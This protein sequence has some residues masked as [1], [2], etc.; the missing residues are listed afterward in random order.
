MPWG[1]K[2][3]GG[4]LGPDEEAW[5]EYDACALIEDG[6]RLPDLLVDQ[7]RGDDFLEGQLKTWLLEQAVRDAGMN[8]S[9]RMHDGYD[10]SYY[11]ISSFMADHIGWHAQ[12]LLA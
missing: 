1:E 12:K 5:R 9:I 4:Y 6:A 7:G 2:A 3:L 8:A 10:H 11:F